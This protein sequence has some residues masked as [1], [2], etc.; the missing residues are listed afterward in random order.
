M[1]KHAPKWG[2][3]D[4]RSS[5]ERQQ[6]AIGSCNDLDRS[7]L[8]GQEQGCVLP[9]GRVARSDLA[10]IMRLN[11]D[12]SGLARIRR[13][14]EIHRRKS[15]GKISQHIDR[16]GADELGASSA[17]NRESRCWLVTSATCERRNQ[18]QPDQ[19]TH[20][21][22]SAVEVRQ[23]NQDC[24]SAWNFG[25]TIAAT[26]ALHSQPWSR[27]SDSGDAPPVT[28]RHLAVPRN[29]GSRVRVIPPPF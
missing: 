9:A 16:G 19:A 27:D 1:L 29:C 2:K 21:V 14:G 22:S 13:I 24:D 10:M 15:V 11:R 4:T 6:L 18:G 23:A 26:A 3:A 12:G 25:E 7:S 20:S 5:R 8:R 17:S 28:P